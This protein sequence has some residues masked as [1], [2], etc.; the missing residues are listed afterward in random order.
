MSGFDKLAKEKK[1]ENMYGDSTQLGASENLKAPERAPLDS[2]N[3]SDEEKIPRGRGK[4][5]KTNR[6]IPFSTRVSPEFDDTI[7][8]LMYEKK[9]KMVELLEDM[10]EAYLKAEKSTDK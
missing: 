1:K 9:R 2:E 8:R 10:L 3:P 6:I 5:K 4:R 7:R